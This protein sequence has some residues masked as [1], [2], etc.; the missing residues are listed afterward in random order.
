M[1]LLRIAGIALVVIVTAC[2]GRSEEVSDPSPP[3]PPISTP[4]VRVEVSG[5]VI[6][7]RYRWPHEPTLGPVATRV[8]LVKPGPRF[9]L[10][11][12]R[13]D[14]VDVRVEAESGQDGA[15]RFWAPPGEY[16]IFALSGGGS[17]AN[18][19]L[20]SEMAGDIAVRIEEG[21]PVRR[22]LVVR[23]WDDMW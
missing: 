11:D 15:F 22:D 6:L 10:R 17:L 19:T 4:D 3:R 12:P 5:T 20:D 23:D 18:D 9:S 16:S 21:K 14:A 13:V 1:R 2:G 8:V 7:H